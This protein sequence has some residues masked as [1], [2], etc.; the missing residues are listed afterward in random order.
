MRAATIWS[1]YQETEKAQDIINAY[2]EE[3][4]VYVEPI[5]KC[6]REKWC[7]IDERNIFVLTTLEEC[8]WYRHA[9]SFKAVS[10]VY[11]HR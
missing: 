2:I 4:F 1:E 11:L 9:S 8:K 3:G 10:C 6:F 5:I 7:Q